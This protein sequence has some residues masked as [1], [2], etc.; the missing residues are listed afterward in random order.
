VYKVE[1]TPS[2]PLYRG[3]RRMVEAL[4]AEGERTV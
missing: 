4:V 2:G 1:E 3:F